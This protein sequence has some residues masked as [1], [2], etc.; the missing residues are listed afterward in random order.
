MRMPVIAAL[1]FV[2]W[3][4]VAH[5]AVASPGV[6]RPHFV[7]GI[8]SWDPVVVKVSWAP[9]ATTG[10]CYRFDRNDYG[11]LTPLALSSPQSTSVR[12][13]ENTDD[14]DMFGFQ[15]QA[16]NCSNPADT[17]PWVAGPLYGSW[18]GPATA[19]SMTGTW[20]Q[21]QNG[22]WYTSEKGA[23]M[24]IGGAFAN[25]GFSA[26]KGPLQGSAKVYVDGVYQSTV[27]LYS[28]Q[29]REHQMVWTKAWP[30]FNQHTITIVNLA[31]SGHPRLNWQ[32]MPSFL[33]CAC[34]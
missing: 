15:V 27:S 14:W 32:W 22:T 6:P 20:L 8:T 21:G 5:A 2:G 28:S 10:A 7:T 3:T 26:L 16:Y 11:D 18:D 25:I 19:V 30:T 1:M 4:G 34:P 31:T 17:S 23:S 29:V 9:S 33:Q 24:A 13:T 12:L